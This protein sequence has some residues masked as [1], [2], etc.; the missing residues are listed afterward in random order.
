MICE[1]DV[2]SETEPEETAK[3]VVV[4]PNNTQPEATTITS[5]ASCEDDVAVQDEVAFQ[6]M[7]PETQK[8]AVEDVT[9][10]S[11]ETLE[12]AEVAEYK[13]QDQAKQEKVQCCRAP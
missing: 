6:K 9:V 8:N 3:M 2:A 10:Q 5:V 11:H 1:E 12:K 7:A 13:H 4:G